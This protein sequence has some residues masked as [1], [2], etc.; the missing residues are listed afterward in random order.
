M[1]F[2]HPDLGKMP[3]TKPSAQDPEWQEYAFR[4]AAIFDLPAKPICDYIGL[5]YNVS[6][7]VYAFASKIA[8][9]R[10]AFKLAAHQ[11]MTKFMFIDT[12]SVVDPVERKHLQL[13]KL[14][15]LKHWTKLDQRRDEMEIVRQT[16]ERPLKDVPTEELKLRLKEM[17]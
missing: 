12:D 2:E 8:A 4:L 15:A 5:N 9:G 17:L 13:L 16:V 3:R 7:G 6:K 1:N 10:A 14:D 11:E